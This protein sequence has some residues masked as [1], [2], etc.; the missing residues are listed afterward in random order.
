MKALL[1]VLLALAIAC[2]GD[3]PTNTSLDAPTNCFT[4][5]GNICMTVAPVTITCTDIPPGFEMNC[6]A[7]VPMNIPT[8]ITTNLIS[9]GVNTGFQDYIKTS[10]II[11]PNTSPGNITAQVPSTKVGAGCTSGT[12]SR[13]VEVYDGNY[14][15]STNAGGRQLFV[16]SVQATFACTH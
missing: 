13:F 9:V 2:G 16:G 11:V 3:A 12:S 15:T 8:T 7:N 14:P 10:I 1:P 5:A 6:S 4:V